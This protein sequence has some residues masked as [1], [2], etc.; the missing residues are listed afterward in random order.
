MIG[1]DG[2]ITGRL[3][4]PKLTTV[5]MPTADAGRMAV[6][7]LIKSMS[8]AT[9]L[10]THLVVREST[11]PRKDSHDK[12]RRR[13][14]RHPR[15][16]NG[17]TARAGQRAA[18]RR[19]PHLR[20]DRPAAGGGRR[21]QRGARPRHAGGLPGAQPVLRRGRRPVRQPHR[22][23]QVHPRRHRV[24]ASAQRRREQ[25]ARR[26]PGLRQAGVAGRVGGSG[27]TA[28]EPDQRGRRGGL[29]REAHRERPVPAGRRH[30]AA[31]V[32]GHDRRPDRR[33]PDQPLLLQPGGHRRRT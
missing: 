16:R 3:Y 14:R 9:V 10:E 32:P 4:R 24:P 19:R 2:S 20:R 33:Q 6:D 23:R 29:P 5:A 18:A 11:A 27:G 28:A 12:S 13:L 7:L 22:A 25:P 30:A 26:R 15:R 21:H 8:A 31:G 1:I 17:R